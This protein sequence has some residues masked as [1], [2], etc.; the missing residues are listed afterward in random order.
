MGHFTLEIHATFQVFVA[1]LL[2]TC[3]VHVLDWHEKNPPRETA[4]MSGNSVIN[5]NTQV[6]KTTL[7]IELEI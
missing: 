7:V 3:L 1:L 4:P 5:I 6:L 2:F